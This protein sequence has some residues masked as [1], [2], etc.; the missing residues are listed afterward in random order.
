M[1]NHVQCNHEQ[2]NYVKDNV[3]C[4]NLHLLCMYTYTLKK[5]LHSR[6]VG[7]HIS[8]GGL[9]AIFQIP[10]GSGSILIFGTFNVKNEF[11]GKCGVGDGPTLP[12]AADASGYTVAVTS[13]AERYCLQHV[14]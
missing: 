7:E 14:E 1:Y 13:L 3:Q 5:K 2:C 9:P 6:G 8:W 10:G 4:K 11:R 12:M